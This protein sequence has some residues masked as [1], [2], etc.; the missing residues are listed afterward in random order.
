M[1][2]RDF[3]FILLFVYIGVLIAVIMILDARVDNLEA[4]DKAF[5]GLHENQDAIISL[6]AENVVPSWIGVSNSL[7]TCM[8]SPSQ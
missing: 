4:V 5:L 3:L 2:F 8:K 7:P 6:L 1:Q